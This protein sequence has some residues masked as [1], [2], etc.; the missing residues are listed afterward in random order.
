MGNDENPLIVQLNW[1]EDEE[2][3]FLLKDQK[4]VSFKKAELYISF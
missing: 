1:L 2:G 3:R 4:N